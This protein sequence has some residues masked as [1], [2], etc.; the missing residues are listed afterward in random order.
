MITVPSIPPGA[1][2]P[3]PGGSRGIG[4]AHVVFCLQART[5]RRIVPT[6]GH[7]T[8]GGSPQ[9]GCS[10]RDSQ[11]GST[12]ACTPG[13]GH[14][15]PGPRPWSERGLFSHPATLAP[16]VVGRRT[17]LPTAEASTLVPVATTLRLSTTEPTATL[18]LGS[19]H[20]RGR[21]PQRGADLVGVDLEDG[22][23]LTLL[24]LEGALLQSALHDDP[25]A[26]GQGLGDVLGVLAPHGAGE[27]HGLAVL[28]FPCLAV[29]GAG[30]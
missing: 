28:P 11:P 18:T 5:I 6:A 14:Q 19:G 15:F 22:P 2:V 30:G 16:R 21:V 8:R 3:T 29:E 23:F 12:P 1:T 27:E 24:G 20:R 4:R 7:P 25:H 13:R 10:R 9:V 26:F 17:T